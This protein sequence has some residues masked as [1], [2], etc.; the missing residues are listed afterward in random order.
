[1][2]PEDLKLLQCYDRLAGLYRLEQRHFSEY[3]EGSG[4]NKALEIVNFTGNSINLDNL[5][6]IKRF[7]NDFKNKYT[8][9]SKELLFGA[10]T[11]KDNNF[12]NSAILFN[13]KNNFINFSLHNLLLSFIFA[14]SASYFAIFA[15][16]E[17][18]CFQT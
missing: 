16:F 17:K 10:I 3:V 18:P 13:D 6:Q 7:K 11:K 8:F 9:N 15:T 1:M 4:N 14:I 12:Y 2:N 5:D